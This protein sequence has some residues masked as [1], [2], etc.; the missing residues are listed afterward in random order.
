M[1]GFPKNYR[2]VLADIKS[3]V[4]YTDLLGEWPLSFLPAFSPSFLTFTRLAKEINRKKTNRT[5]R[6]I[7]HVH[8]G[9][10]SDEQLKEVARTWLY[11]YTILV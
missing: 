10:P 5:Y 9:A 2:T 1:P 8:M 7:T 6:C 3:E 4:G 11:I